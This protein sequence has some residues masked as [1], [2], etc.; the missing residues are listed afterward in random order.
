MGVVGPLGKVLGPKGLMP[1][2]KNGT[3]AADVEAAVR[4]FKGG[5]VEYRTSK[6]RRSTIA[7]RQA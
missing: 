2:P 5:K 4:E 1:T 3:V 7:G 6:N